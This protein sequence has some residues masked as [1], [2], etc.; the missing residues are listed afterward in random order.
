MGLLGDRSLDARTKAV[1]GSTEREPSDTLLERATLIEE[2]PSP[3][4]L[5]GTAR[6]L[7]IIDELR[8]AGFTPDELLR[9]ALNANRDDLGHSAP[10]PAMLEHLM[11]PAAARELADELLALPERTWRHHRLASVALVKLGAVDARDEE[12]VTLDAEPS[13]LRAIIG[14]LPRD[15][16]EALVLKLATPATGPNVDTPSNAL[17]IV[18]QLRLIW[19]LVESPATT[20]ARDHAL[21][22]G[23]VGSDYDRV[24]ELLGKPFV[25]EERP[26]RAAMRALAHWTA[27]R[28]NAL[29]AKQ[30]GPRA[31]QIWSEHNITVDAKELATVEAWTAASPARQRE[32]ALAVVAAVEKFTGMPTKLVDI[33]AHGGPPIALLDLDGLRFCLVPG[34]TFELGFS[35]EEEAAV[36][37]QAEVDAD[38]DNHYEL[39]ESLLDQV[40]L[41]RPIQRV[42]VGPLLAMQ[43]PGE[44][45]DLHEAAE[46]LANTYLRVPSEAEWEYLARGGKARELTYRG[47][48]VPVEAA[49]FRETSAA[50]PKGGNAFRMWGFGIEPELC[51]DVMSETHD[52]L[53]LDGSPRRGDGPRVV[54]GGAGQLFPWQDTGEW[55][56]MLSAMRVSQ[57]I[58]EFN[59]ALRYVLGI[60][61]Q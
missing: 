23:K 7:G 18:K 53:P 49:Y 9:V 11:S 45:Y 14:A 60:R 51:A 47:D 42:T 44:G 54:R 43:G 55:H 50:G 8:A 39:Y 61:C 6:W 33:V 35:E 2:A 5:Q 12:L 10:N 37:A 41:M 21:E 25:P 34:G 28:A 38:S 19:D 40:D 26:T 32:I 46:V 1:I 16:R 13:R 29:R 30:I 15:R 24:R 3:A 27:E 57:Q 58:W 31:A 17:F 59:I 4:M 22:V 20:A 52:D 36:R 56:L 48:V